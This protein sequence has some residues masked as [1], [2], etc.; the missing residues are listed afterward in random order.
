M[1]LEELTY[2][3]GVMQRFDDIDAGIKK[4]DD[5]VSYTNGKVR[6]IILAL[7]AVTFLTIGLG[8]DKIAIILPLLG[9]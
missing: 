3:Q 2:R 7:V 6:K 8:I 5:K 9:V 4:V 1:P